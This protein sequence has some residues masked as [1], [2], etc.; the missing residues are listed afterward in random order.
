M[1]VRL[2]SEAD[3]PQLRVLIDASV[4]GLGLFRVANRK[5]EA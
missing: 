5:P 1:R 3:V 4:R 2:A